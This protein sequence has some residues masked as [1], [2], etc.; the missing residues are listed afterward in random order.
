MKDKTGTEIVME[1]IDG[2]E[3]ERTK[4][5]LD[6]GN[7]QRGFGRIEFTDRYGAKC[8]L[9][10]SS[11]AT[12]SAIW[13]GPNEAEPQICVQGKGWQP[14]PVPEEVMMTTRMHLTQSMVKQLLP[15]L[16]DFAETGNYLNAM[17]EYKKLQKREKKEKT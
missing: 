8:S 11:L 7:T 2:E 14:Y 5:I 13:F 4:T 17:D 1:T 15:F 3:Y 16:T 10:D 6:V 12:E 9:Q